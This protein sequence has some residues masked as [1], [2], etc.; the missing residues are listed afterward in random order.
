MLAGDFRTEDD[1]IV[2]SLDFLF[3]SNISDLQ[4]KELTIYAGKKKN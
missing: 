4:W 2:S 3:I 1:Q